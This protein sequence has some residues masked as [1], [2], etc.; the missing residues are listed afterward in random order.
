[1][2]KTFVAGLAALVLAGAG[3][4]VWSRISMPGAGSGRAATG[5]MVAVAMPELA[6]PA[7]VGQKVFASRC[8]ACHGPNAGGIEGSGPPL[9]HDFYRPGH[10]ADAAFVLAAQ[11]GVRAHH[12]RFGDIPPVEGISRAEID[13]AIAFVRRVQA[14]NGVL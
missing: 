6:G 9:V 13:A 14:A 1:M 2:R 10:H 4:A 3:A 12:W 5:E 7:A 11:N 8:A